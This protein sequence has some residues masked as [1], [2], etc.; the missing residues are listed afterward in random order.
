MVRSGLRV[1]CTYQ[2]GLTVH[3]FVVRGGL[4]AMQAV[5]KDAIVA[6]E[7]ADAGR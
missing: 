3:D 2:Q 1:S 4:C 6:Q 5:Q 7:D